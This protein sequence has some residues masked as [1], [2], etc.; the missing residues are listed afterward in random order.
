MIYVSRNGTFLSKNIIVMVR[1]LGHK[2][3]NYNKLLVPD[4]QGVMLPV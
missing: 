4:F 2:Q 1:L 3:Y